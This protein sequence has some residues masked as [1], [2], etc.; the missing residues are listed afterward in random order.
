MLAATSCELKFRHPMSRAPMEF[1][2][3]LPDTLKAL[4]HRRRR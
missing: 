3:E 1:C 4:I 2:S